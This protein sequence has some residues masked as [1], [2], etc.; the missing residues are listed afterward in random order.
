VALIAL[1]AWSPWEE[2]TEVE[3]LS[4]YRAWSDGVG[5][6]LQTGLAISRPECETTFDDEVGEPRERLRPVAAAAR[7]S[8]AAL[9]PAGWQSGK[10]GVVR[11][12]MDAHDDLLPPRRR[13]DLSDVVG[14]RL[15]VRPDVYCWQPA[16]WAPFF[17]QYAIV[18][19]GEETSLKGIADGTRNRI[20]LEPGACAGLSWYLRRARPHP[21]SY[22]NFETAEAL[23]V[24]AHQAEHLKV[25]TASEAAVACSAVQHV[26][27]LIRA[28]GWGAEYASEL[29]LQA[30]DLSYSQL[31]PAFRSPACRDGGPLDRNPSSNAWP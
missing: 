7:R 29:A 20:D 26:R 11:A 15:G 21:L 16:G 2:P 22:E 9:T 28:A 31:P 12:L 24:L 13:P 27:P 1:F 17:E 23:M 4:G 10:A 30:W 3:W 8:C 6:S 5:A 19:G 18:R 25:P 14:S